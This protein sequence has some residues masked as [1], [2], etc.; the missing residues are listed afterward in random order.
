MQFQLNLSSL[1]KLAP[2][3]HAT[4]VAG[5]LALIGLMSERGHAADVVLETVVIVNVIV[6]VLCFLA[7][8]GK[9]VITVDAA[10]PGGQG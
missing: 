7:Q 2:S 1:R 8:L 5:N 4:P 9:H 6:L 3:P 10:S